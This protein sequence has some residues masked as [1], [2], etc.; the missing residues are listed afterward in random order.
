V[1]SPFKKKKEEEWPGVWNVGNVLVDIR[2]LNADFDAWM[3][4]QVAEGY[5]PTD[6]EMS[7]EWN[8]RF[9]EL[10]TE[11]NPPDETGGEWL[12]FGIDERGFVFNPQTREYGSPEHLR[13]AYEFFPTD[14]RPGSRVEVLRRS[15]PD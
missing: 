13:E 11:A 5:H 14:S 3:G 4:E 7:I 1:R 12:V 15:S 10:A 6:D 9:L 2:R 8:R